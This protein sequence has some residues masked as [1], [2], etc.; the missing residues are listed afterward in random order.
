[1]THDLAEKPHPNPW[2]IVL[3]MAGVFLLMLLFFWSTRYFAYCEIYPFLNFAY[4]LLFG[5]AGVVLG[6][7]ISI[8]GKF[9]E[10]FPWAISASAGIATA[11]VG[12][13]I[14]Y[15]SHK[16]ECGGPP[17]YTMIITDLPSSLSASPGSLAPSIVIPEY[18]PSISAV[19]FR[20]SSYKKDITVTF[21]ASSRFTLF[22]H[23]L[24]LKDNKYEFNRTCTLTFETGLPPG[25]MDAQ[26]IAREG[27]APRFSFD[28]NYFRRLEETAKSGSQS[29][30]ENN[31]LSA[32][33]LDNSANAQPISPPFYVDAK[34]GDG[35]SIRFVQKPNTN[36][37]SAP[38]LNQPD[39]GSGPIAKGKAVTPNET[40]ESASLDPKLIEQLQARKTKTL[41]SASNSV[42]QIA[43]IVLP[44]LPEQTTAA[45]RLQPAASEPT[46]PSKACRD[47]PSDSSLT[48]VKQF[49]GGNDLDFTTRKSI[50]AN[51]DDVHCHV[52]SILFDPARPITQRARALRLTT[53]GLANIDD[54]KWQPGTKTYRDF[55][56]PIPLLSRAEE[57]YIFALTQS[58]A[59]ALR[60]QALLFVRTLPSNSI[61]DR[62][63]KIARDIDSLPQPYKERHAIAAIYFYYNRIVEYLNE[64][65]GNPLQ[66][67]L[68]IRAEIGKYTARVTPWLRD[69]LF[70]NGNASSYRA[71]IAYATAIVEREKKLTNEQGRANFAK[72]LAELK[73]SSDGYPSNFLHIAQALAFVD[74]AQSQPILERI[75]KSQNYPPA[76]FL[77]DKAGNS[78]A[79]LFAGP[80]DF[81]KIADKFKPDRN[82][83]LLMRFNEWDM[84]LGNGQVGWMRRQANTASN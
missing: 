13:L 31:C 80:G 50:Y 22:L 25:K 55:S 6:G 18:D 29:D 32:R 4:P 67:R 7:Q 38:D 15:N 79:E 63:T 17:R 58:N 60:E 23:V 28:K 59:D 57:D 33:A 5:T 30:Y 74:G 16:P 44:K 54:R 3:P 61:E 53:F 81:S 11:L 82:V 45:P 21:D 83:R 34:I 48:L 73:S 65:P 66:E 78:T 42:P 51:W 14:A 75:K 47:T 69:P 12:F 19:A 68:M 72:M 41:A 37:A 8:Q 27:S 39:A 24:Q 43:P 9:I 71:M 10:P 64:P 36:V 77:E 40:K 62:L 84:V 26:A 1:M 20:G 2:S 56:M 49:I 52:L 35:A 46:P 76:V 70:S